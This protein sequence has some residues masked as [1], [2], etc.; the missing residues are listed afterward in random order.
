[1]SI[2]PCPGASH[3]VEWTID[4]SGR[5]GGVVDRARFELAASSMPRRRSSE[6]IY[7]PAVEPVYDLMV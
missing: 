4:L 3:T 7:R 6:L 2:I 5:R 1:V